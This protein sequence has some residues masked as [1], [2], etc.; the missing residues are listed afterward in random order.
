M[1]TATDIE[2][3]R[4]ELEKKKTEGEM[5]LKQEELKLQYAQFEVSQKQK[6]WTVSPVTTAILA[7]TVGLVA[8]IL[9]GILNLR[10][11][12]QKQEG[13]MI[14]EGIKT[15]DTKA[16]SRNLL[17]F[18]EA[19]LIHL[20]KEQIEKLKK[21]AGESTIPVLPRPN[22]GP[23]RINFTSSA[24]LTPE[25]K[26]NLSKILSSFQKY[27]KTIGF[28]ISDDKVAVTITPGLDPIAY[29]EPSEKSITVGSEYADD[30]NTV[31]RQYAHHLLM[32][33]NNSIPNDNGYYAIESGLASYFPCSFSNHPIIGDKSGAASKGL[34]SPQ[35]LVNNRKFSEIS[36][37]D[38]ASVQTDGSEVW[39]G[40]FWEIH[41]LLGQE[42]ADKLLYSTWVNLK[43]STNEG[44]AYPYFVRMLQDADNTIEGGKHVAEIQGV[45]KRR[46]LTFLN[47]H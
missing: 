31:L 17:F 32:S 15:G 8:T 34:D 28:Q 20:S 43:A 29:Y 35:K 26:E 10:V 39:G 1:S 30:S 36:L 45:L 12:R 18:S 44:R 13:S 7:G 4:L 25:V 21:E 40:A 46:G 47:E 6:R 16:A 42:M 38:W 19:G 41:E 33:S 5:K 24:A 27:S 9:G 37:K 23:E 2:I 11:E 3:Q 14:L 22:A